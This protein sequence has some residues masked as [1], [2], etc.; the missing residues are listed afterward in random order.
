MTKFYSSFLLTGLL[1]TLAAC[2]E[3]GKQATVNTADRTCVAGYVQNT[4]NSG[5]LEIYTKSGI[6]DEIQTMTD[7]SSETA[8]DI[9]KQL[10]IC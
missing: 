2:A 3:S 6:I 9:T 8:D 4:N 5:T 10:G 1:F 7:V